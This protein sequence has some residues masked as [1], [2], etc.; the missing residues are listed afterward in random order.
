MILEVQLTNLGGLLDV[1][2]L[3]IV[4]QQELVAAGEALEG[5][6]VDGTWA[7]DAHTSSSLYNNDQYK[8]IDSIAEVHLIS[9]FLPLACPE[10][11]CI[12]ALTNARSHSSPY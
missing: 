7:V 12:A 5:N 6:A 1:E 2:P 10:V 4:L 11:H 9:C 3:A 8:I